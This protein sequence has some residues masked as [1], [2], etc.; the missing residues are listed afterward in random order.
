VLE[1]GNDGAESLFAALLPKL[2]VVAVEIDEREL[3]RDE[4]AGSEAERNPDREE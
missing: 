3:R 1:R 2:E 4:D